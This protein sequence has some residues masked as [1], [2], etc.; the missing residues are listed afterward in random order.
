M[1]GGSFDLRNQLVKQSAMGAVLVGILAGI[2]W[3]GLQHFFELQ[4][5]QS[6]FKATRNL[7]HEVARLQQQYRDANPESLESDL[8]TVDRRLLGNFTQLTQWAEALQEKGRTLGLQTQYHILKTEKTTSPVDG[9]TVI[10]LKFLAVQ[11]D[12]PT[13]YLSFVRFLKEMDKTGPRV[14]IQE[15]TI[16]GDGQQATQLDVG[17]LVWMKSTGSV[18]L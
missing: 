1:N 17:L 7:E 2:G 8:Q 9:V 15:M 10:P 5:S 6:R 18:E 11:K 4:D 14:D 3:V 16:T 13:G 12:S